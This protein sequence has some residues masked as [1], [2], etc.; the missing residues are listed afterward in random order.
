MNIEKSEVFFLFILYIVHV[1]SCDCSNAL[2]YYTA[3]LGFTFSSHH[4]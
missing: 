4:F 3:K 2:E 1:A